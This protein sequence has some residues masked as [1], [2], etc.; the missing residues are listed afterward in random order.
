MGK[1]VVSSS[2]SSIRRM[3][4]D[5]TP[6]T[7]ANLFVTLTISPRFAEMLPVMKLAEASDTLVWLVE[8]SVP[9]WITGIAR[10]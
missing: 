10:M 3:V 7:T 6:F 5:S 4:S 8:P 1:S 2:H 9:V